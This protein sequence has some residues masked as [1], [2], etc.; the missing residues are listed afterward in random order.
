MTHPPTPLLV[1]RG[2]RSERRLWTLLAALFTLVAGV[3]V[4]LAVDEAAWWQAGVGG[5][6]LLGA[7]AC[8]RAARRTRV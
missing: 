7:G 5:L 6:L 8:L 1:P 4:L 3:N 2:E